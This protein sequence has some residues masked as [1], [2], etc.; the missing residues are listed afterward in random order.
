M[1]KIIGSFIIRDEGEGNYFFKFRTNLKPWKCNA[2]CTK[3]NDVIIPNKFEGKYTF[4]WELRN[5]EVNID[6]GVITIT[7]TYE[8]MYDLI[9]RDESNTISQYYGQGMSFGK[10][11]IGSF[12]NEEFNKDIPEVFTE[13]EGD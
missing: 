4:V 13:V 5:D 11:L 9:W 7:R 1:K 10:N 6:T 2:V 12:W 8:G 3:R